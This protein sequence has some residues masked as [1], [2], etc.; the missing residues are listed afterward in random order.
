MP[1]PN[2]GLIRH[3][4][5]QIPM[6]ISFFQEY[7]PAEI[8]S[9]VKW[10]EMK[11]LN[12]SFVD[13]NLRQSESDLLYEVPWTDE[14]AGPEAKGTK[15]LIYILFEHQSTLDPLMHIRLLEYLCRIWRR[16]AEKDARKALLPPI[17]PFVLTH[18]VGGWKLSQQFHDRI[19]W[20]KSEP[21][22]AAL[23]PLMPKF[24]HLLLDLCGTPLEALRGEPY[25]RLT[26][27]VLKVRSQRDDGTWFDWAIPVIYDA[28]KL[29]QGP[30]RTLFRYMFYAA[31]LKVEDFR[32]KIEASPL[33][34]E[35]A[36]T[37]MTLADHLIAEGIEKGELVGQVRALQKF[38]GLAVDPTST[39]ATQSKEQLEA[40]IERLTQTLDR[41]MS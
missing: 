26:L 27:G 28:Q 37:I 9:A 17:I 13:E 18:A 3:T 31:E 22:R 19:Q 2:D 33:F 35:T 40:Q 36:E 4:F 41:R 39:L 34:K 23:E 21:V 25:V 16:L 30:L 20:P 32:A 38:L 8:N 29:G 12:S 14:A 7:L 24:E 11:L 1:Q 10:D 15:L 5:G 6:A